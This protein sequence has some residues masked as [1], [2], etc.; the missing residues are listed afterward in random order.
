MSYISFWCYDS[1]G[2]P[3]G[4][5]VSEAKTSDLGANRNGGDMYLKRQVKVLFSAAALKS[6]I[7][8]SES[9]VRWKSGLPHISYI[10]SH[11]MADH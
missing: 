2:A 3:D 1:I 8:Q 11:M 5:K 9:Y 7:K 6:K 4:S 10:V